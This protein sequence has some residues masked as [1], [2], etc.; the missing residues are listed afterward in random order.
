MLHGLAWAEVV[1]CE[2][3][4]A[5]RKACLVTALRLLIQNTA[6]PI[7]AQKYLLA[8]ATGDKRWT[9]MRPPLLPLAAETGETLVKALDAE[10][11]F[12]LAA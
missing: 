10:C 4:N 6:P 11:G 7:P 9:N 5:C 12:R 3:S 2:H 8:R 1:V